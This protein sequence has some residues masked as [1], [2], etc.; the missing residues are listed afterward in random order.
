M[1]TTLSRV[2]AAGTL[3]AGLL[4]VGA[5]PIPTA[6]LPV[7]AAA[8]SSASK[9]SAGASR[10]TTAPLNL[11]KGPGQSYGV[12][13]VL[14]KGVRVTLT[15]RTAN[16]FAQVRNGSGTGWVSTRY[17]SGSKAVAKSTPRRLATPRGLKPNA[18]KTYR[19]AVTRFPNIRTVHGVRPEANSDH[20][21]GRAVDLMI[22]NYRSASGKNFGG[23][24]AAWARA[25]A[26]SLGV[27]YVIWNQRIWSVARSSEGWRAMANR[28]GDSAN[29][30]DH[31]HISVR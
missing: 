16:G 21:T 23:D 5:A 22:P 9:A 24:V 11:R 7:A 20:S 26:R 1:P 30:K 4:F 27:T 12:S 31:V 2:I 10:T 15:G 28:G 25:N 29:H 6:V 8:T 17:L 13:K 18:A 14:R 3:S 19:A